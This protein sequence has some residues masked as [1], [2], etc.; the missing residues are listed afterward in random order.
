MERTA[1]SSAYLVVWHAAC[2]E[3][4]GNCPRT[5]V[6]MQL[7]CII[8]TFPVTGKVQLLLCIR[9]EIPKLPHCYFPFDWDSPTIALYEWEIPRVASLVISLW[10]KC[11]TKTQSCII[12]TFPLTGKFLSCIIGTFPVTG[13]VQ[14]LLCIR[15]EIPK[16]PHCYFPFDWDSPTIALYEWEIPEL[17]HWYFPFDWECPTKTL[18][19]KKTLQK[20]KPSHRWRCVYS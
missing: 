3:S 4:S 10:L 2:L 8:G 17:H 11:P 19:H 7:S 18:H 16:L 1:H 12:G 14:L 15:G 5:T 6:D 20:K 9:G 13:K